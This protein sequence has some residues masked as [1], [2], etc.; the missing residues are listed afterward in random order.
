MGPRSAPGRGGRA[1][2]TKSAVPAALLLLG[3]VEEPAAEA[4][5]R[6]EADEAP[7]K[8][9]RAKKSVAAGD[10]EPKAKKPAAKK[11]RAK[12]AEPAAT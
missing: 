6:D 8:K 10:A 7:V 11:T 9:P 2:A 4:S 3:M 5:T 12:K 1:G